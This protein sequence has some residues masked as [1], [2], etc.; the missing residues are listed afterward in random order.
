[1]VNQ[2]GYVLTLTNKQKGIIC[3]ILSAFSFALM[4][5]FVKM[6]G[7][8]PFIQKSFFRNFIAFVCAAVLLIRTEEKFKF[9]KKNL[10]VLLIRSILGT[11]G[12]LCNFYAIDN[13]LLSD[14]SMLNKLSP[15]FVIIFSYFFLKEKIKPFQIFAITV[16]FIGCLFIIKPGFLSITQSYAS[17][18]GLLGGIFAGAA[19]TAVRKLTQMGERNAFIVFFFSGF[20]CLSTLPYIIF[21]SEPMTTSQVMFLLLS[22]LAA[23]GGQFGITAAYSFAPSREISVFDYTNIIFAAILGFIF[24][25][26]IPDVY[27]ILGYI[28]ICGI[29]IIMFFYNNKQG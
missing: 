16:A 17:I 13:L 18:I 1:M 21:C 9:E 19:Y 26:Q 15:F 8:L 4:N 29:S 2:E 10:G 25:G 27:S 24:F 20:S 28:I 3:I 12:I 7:D 6:A 5:A 14:A 11:L 22:G 23:T